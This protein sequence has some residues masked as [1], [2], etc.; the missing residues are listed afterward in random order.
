MSP[1]DFD[2]LEALAARA[3]QDHPGT[4]PSV[5][6]EILRRVRAQAPPADTSLWIIA[7]LSCAAALL[8][9]V[10]LYQQSGGQNPLEAVAQ[11]TQWIT[12]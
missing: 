6:P 2:K 7:G 12:L 1:Q 8:A 10:D 3:R 11:Y 5:A 9:A 4:Q